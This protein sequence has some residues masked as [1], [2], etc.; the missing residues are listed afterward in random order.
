[1]KTPQTPT[2]LAIKALVDSIVSSLE[3]MQ[4]RAVMAQEAAQIGEI[5]GAVGALPFEQVDALKSQLDAVLALHRL[6]IQGPVATPADDEESDDD[7]IENAIRP[8]LDRL[9]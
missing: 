4:V 1:M 9:P 5:N 6:N 2:N 7:Q 3:A 8:N